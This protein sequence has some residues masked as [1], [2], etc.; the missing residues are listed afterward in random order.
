MSPEK[1]KRQVSYNAE[2]ILCPYCKKRIRLNN[3]G[4]A[5]VHLSGKTGSERCAGSEVEPRPKPDNVVD[6]STMDNLVEYG[7]FIDKLFSDIG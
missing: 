6:Y 4:K 5:R 3:N 2:A 1:P 7:T